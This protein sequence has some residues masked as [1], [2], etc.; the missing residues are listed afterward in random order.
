[1]HLGQGLLWPELPIRAQTLSQKIVYKVY[2]IQFFGFS[3]VWCLF[4]MGDKVLIKKDMS[5]GHFIHN[6]HFILQ[7]FLVNELKIFLVQILN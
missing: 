7:L 2:L 1:M 3:I 5:Y 4:P 6:E